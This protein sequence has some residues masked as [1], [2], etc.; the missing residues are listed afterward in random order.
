MSAIL[1]VAL[2]A[3][4][5]LTWGVAQD[6]VTSSV[7]RN[8]ILAQTGRRC[9]MVALTAVEEALDYLR[10]EANEEPEPGAEDSVGLQLRSLRPGEMAE[11][12]VVPEVSKLP[13]PGVRIQSG[14][15]TVRAT[16]RELHVPEQDGPSEEYCEKL[17]QFQLKWSQVPG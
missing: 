14:P 8:V 1:L 12:T 9:Q 5:G 4:M 13:S 6:F 7:R 10:V 2:V 3:I 15:V 16:L 11:F 17:R